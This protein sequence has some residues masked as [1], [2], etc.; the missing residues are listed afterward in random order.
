MAIQ[1]YS[2]NHVAYTAINQI[3]LWEKNVCYISYNTI[4]GSMPNIIDKCD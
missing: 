2:F 1:K 3:Q 4:K